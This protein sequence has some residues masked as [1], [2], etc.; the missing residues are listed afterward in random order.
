MDFTFDF[1][2]KINFGFKT[3]PELDMEFGV[4]NNISIQQP[5]PPPPEII[6]IDNGLRA[7]EISDYIVFEHKHDLL[8][9]ITDNMCAGSF[10]YGDGYDITAGV[11]T[12]DFSYEKPNII[13]SDLYDEMVAGGFIETD[14]IAGVTD[15]EARLYKNV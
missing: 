12:D 13:Y 9:P 14:I 7:G 6:Y 15:D 4:N 10:E 1:G 2:K 11:T 8:I 5:E 3:K